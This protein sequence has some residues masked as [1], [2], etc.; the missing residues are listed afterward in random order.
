MRSTVAYACGLS[1]EAPSQAER[2][3][4]AISARTNGELTFRR[5]GRNN[6]TRATRELDTKKALHARGFDR[7]MVKKIM[8]RTVTHVGASDLSVEQWLTIALRY[9][10]KT[11]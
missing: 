1:I 3:R 7:E 11:M 10:E 6:F 5:E 8:A 2:S 9:A 4:G